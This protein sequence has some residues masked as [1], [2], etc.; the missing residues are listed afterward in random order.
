M[1][2]SILASTLALL[3]VSTPALAHQARIGNLVIH[4][5]WTRAT[6]SGAAVAGGYTIIENTGK[7]A[8]RLVGGGIGAAAGFA[9]HDMAMKDGVMSMS[10]VEGGLEIP[11]GGKVELKPGGLHIMFTGLKHA[12]KEGE[13]EEGTLV[14]EKAGTLKLDFMVEAM[15]AKG[16]HGIMAGHDD[17][18]GE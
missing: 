18:A 3:L 16:G 4:H 11:A 2:R 12:L 10:P 17:M 6:P 9:L 14:F 13:M 7:T 5:P 1:H 15:G 8:D